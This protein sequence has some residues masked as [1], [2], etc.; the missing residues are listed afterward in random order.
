ML[1]SKSTVNDG[2]FKM[3]QYCRWLMLHVTIGWLNSQ[4]R[5]EEMAHRTWTIPHALWFQWFPFFQVSR[6]AHSG[7]PIPVK[8]LVHR[9]L[10]LVGSLEMHS[11]G[12][13]HLIHTLHCT[14]AIYSIFCFNK[15]NDAMYCCTRGFSQVSLR[16]QRT[17]SSSAILTADS[18]SSVGQLERAVSRAPDIAAEFVKG[19]DRLWQPML[20]Y[21]LQCIPSALLW[22]VLL[23]YCTFPDSFRI[24]HRKVCCFS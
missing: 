15:V 10:R 23:Q 21:K 5:G 2:H 11:D 9:K 8:W 1:Y 24:A 20:Q 14:C 4:V 13:R 7:A 22:I 17:F 6:A 19:I 18:A 3:I 12:I 16:I